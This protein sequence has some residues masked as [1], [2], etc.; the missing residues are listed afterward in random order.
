LCSALIAA[1]EVNVRLDRPRAALVRAETRD[2]SG[3]VFFGGGHF[4]GPGGGGI[5]AWLGLSR[6][7]HV[8]VGRP[9]DY[10][11]PSRIF[12]SYRRG[13]PDYW[14]NPVRGTAMLTAQGAARG[15]TAP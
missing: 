7:V 8:A 15:F 5:D 4:R 12:N 9:L 10:R 13:A 11:S 1:S 2:G 14:W 3:V 6:V